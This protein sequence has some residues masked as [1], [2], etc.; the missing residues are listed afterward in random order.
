MAAKQTQTPRANPLRRI[1][2]INDSCELNKKNLHWNTYMSTRRGDDGEAEGRWVAPSDENTDHQHI[3]LR[4]DCQVPV[5]TNNYA[6][7]EFRREILK[8]YHKI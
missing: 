3:D 8:S 6:Y 1:S 2:A 4:A 5:R 7:S